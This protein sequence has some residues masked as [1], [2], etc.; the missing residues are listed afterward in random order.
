MHLAACRGWPV[1]RP[2]PWV[3]QGQPRPWASAATCSLETSAVGTVPVPC[4]FKVLRL[5]IAKWDTEKD[6]LQAVAAG[7]HPP[8]APSQ[9]ISVAASARVPP[10]DVTSL[11]AFPASEGLR[12]MFSA[13]LAQC[14]SC[15]PTS[16]AGVRSVL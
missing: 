1:P 15:G 10:G 2:S 5:D 16:A 4:S 12:D 7:T 9:P 8:V 6:K 13:L 11:P 14:A 3:P